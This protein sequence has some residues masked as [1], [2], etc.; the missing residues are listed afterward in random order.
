MKH[1]KLAIVTGSSGSIGS[2]IVDHFLAEGWGVVGIDRV[3]PRK[4]AG[5][6]FIKAN[7]ASVRDIQRIGKTVRTRHKT[8]LALVNNAAEQIV[9]P[10]AKTTPEEWDHTMAVNVRAAYLLMAELHDYISLAQGAVINIASVHATATS[11]G[12]AAYVASKGALVAL[13]RAMA[14]EFAPQGIRVNAVLPGAIH[15]PMLIAGLKRSKL[16]LDSFAERH[17]LGRVG[18]PREVAEAVYFFADFVASGFITGQTLIVDGGATARLS[19]E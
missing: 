10:L 17:P 1:E 9:K 14:L 12:M 13:T 2:A 15:T 18:V 6:E 4:K 16:T 19:T 3:A 11:P 5:L 8:V 7:L